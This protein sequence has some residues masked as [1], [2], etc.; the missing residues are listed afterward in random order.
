MTRITIRTILLSVAI[1]AAAAMNGFSMTG[2]TDTDE[3]NSYRNKIGIDMT[4]D[5]FSTNVID[6]GA[7]GLH[8]AGLV[9][10][11][12]E[13]YKEGTYSRVFHHAL[14]ECVKPLN[15]KYFHVRKIKFVEATKN[16]SVI[17]LVFTVQLDSEQT[18][19]KKTDVTFRFIDGVSESKMTN[20]LFSMMSRYVQ[21]REAKKRF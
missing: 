15:N 6:K 20:E 11:L 12:L 2:P 16:D 17:D 13:N 8:L 1:L 19:L 5:D 18:K 10:F 4:V 7:M 9:D 21:M 3:I 14:R